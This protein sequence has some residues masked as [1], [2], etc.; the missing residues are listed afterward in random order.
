MS[1]KNQTSEAI[2]N[3]YIRQHCRKMYFL[4]FPVFLFYLTAAIVVINFDMAGHLNEPLAPASDALKVAINWGTGL[5]LVIAAFRP[6]IS[7]GYAIHG[8]I[9][10]KDKP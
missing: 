8:H 10:W 4:N 9:V 3:A 7:M 5:F 1:H 6:L 2:R